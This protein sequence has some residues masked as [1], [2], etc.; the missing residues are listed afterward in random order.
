MA[1]RRLHFA[2]HPQEALVVVRAGRL[3]VVLN[4][5]LAEPVYLQGKVDRRLA[6]LEQEELERRR[7][8]LEQHEMAEMEDVRGYLGEG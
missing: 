6:A 5:T 8:R 7:Q 3:V 1:D 4:H 2:L